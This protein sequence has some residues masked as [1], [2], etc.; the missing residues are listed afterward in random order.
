MTSNFSTTEVGKVEIEYKHETSN[1][2]I[3]NLTIHFYT[4]F[5]L[6]LLLLCYNVLSLECVLYDIIVGKCD[7]M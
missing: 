4:L 6:L 3:K 1:S 2:I 5:L 7:I